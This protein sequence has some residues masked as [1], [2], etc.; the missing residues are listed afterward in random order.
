MENQGYHGFD[1]P[2]EET[3][4]TPPEPPPA[5][6]TY[7]ERLQEQIEAE[8]ARINAETESPFENGPARRAKRGG[9]WMRK[10]GL[11]MLGETLGA[12]ITAPYRFGSEMV[13]GGGWGAK[14]VGALLGSLVG[15]GIYGG[16]G[17][18][19]AYLND[20]DLENSAW[21]K[22]G[23]YFT[24]GF[25]IGRNQD[26]D[27]TD[28]GGLSKEDHKAFV[29]AMTG[30]DGAIGRF[31][32]NYGALKQRLMGGEEFEGYRTGVLEPMMKKMAKA[33]PKTLKAAKA[34]MLGMEPDE[35]YRLNAQAAMKSQNA[36]GAQTM[37][38]DGSPK[39]TAKQG[40][41]FIPYPFTTTKRVKLGGNREVAVEYQPIAYRTK[42]NVARFIGIPTNIQDLYNS[43]S[44]EEG[45]IETVKALV[46]NPQDLSIS[47]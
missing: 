1:P 2:L 34:D 28:P 19:I 44:I 10:K 21:G 29:Q 20:A 45:D 16:I 7:A 46:Y 30:P 43:G 37:T 22:V 24:P 31:G 42:T 3:T 38:S 40:P 11:P 9:M 17:E 14:S 33:D 4:P 5:P 32:Y 36:Q 23:S 27:P 6:K 18:G 39:K 25:G 8:R 26:Y 12:P 13:G 41:P 35:Y 15:T 47:E